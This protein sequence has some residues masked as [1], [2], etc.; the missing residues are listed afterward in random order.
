F[1]RELREAEGR[2]ERGEPAHLA[3]TIVRL[4]RVSIVRNTELEERHA[5]EIDESIRALAAL[6]EDVVALAGDRGGEVARR[7][8]E[9]RFPFGANRVVPRI[10]VRGSSEGISLDPGFRSQRP[11]T[12]DDKR[13]LIARG[14]EL[15][16]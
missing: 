8:D 12:E 7:F 2:A 9:A 14:Y 15:T 11:W 13:L 6:R 1:V 10:V 16:D 3:D 5:T 4:A